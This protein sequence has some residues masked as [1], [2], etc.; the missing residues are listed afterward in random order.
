MLVLS[1]AVGQALLCYGQAQTQP[2]SQTKVATVHEL[3]PG[4]SDGSAMHS[5]APPAARSATAAD[6]G[7]ALAL[8]QELAAMKARMEQISAQLAELKRREVVA[9]TSSPAETSVKVEVLPA[10]TA[11]AQTSSDSSIAAAAQKAK[12]V[13]FSDW[14]WTWLNGNP[15]N[16][17]TAFDSKFFTPEIR[18][19][20]YLQLRFQQTNRQLDRRIERTVSRQRN[21]IGTTRPDSRNGHNG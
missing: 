13:P 8:E 20:Y 16:K 4:G 2:D 19:R 12:I 3:V 6:L 9:E 14:D 10:A 15:R 7:V 11:I 21:P 18:G 17:D 5:T 1:I